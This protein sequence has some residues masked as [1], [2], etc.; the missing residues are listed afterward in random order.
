MASSAITIEDKGGNKLI[1]DKATVSG[2]TSG[3]LTR[4]EDA[5]D[6]YATVSYNSNGR[7]SSITTSDSRSID[8]SYNSSNLLSS[9][10]PSNGPVVYYT[11]SSNRLTTVTY[12]DSK[13]STYT[14]DGNKNLISARNHTGYKIVYT[15]ESTSNATHPHRVKTITEYAG[16][17]LGQSLTATYGWNTTLFTDHLGRKET[18]QFNNLG[19]LIAIRDTDGSAQYCAYMSEER[20]QSK[21]SSVSK[22]QKT[23]INLCSDSSFENDTAWLYTP[24]SECQISS[25]LAYMG[26]HCLKLTNH[27]AS[28]AQSVSQ[29]QS[30]IANEGQSVTLSAYFKGQSGAKLQLRDANHVVI[31]EKS[32]VCSD[33]WSR[34]SVA[35]TFDSDGYLGTMHLYIVLPA[36]Q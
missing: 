28:N 15:Y 31:A 8:L 2:V 11:Y 12:A 17:T 13:Q 20:M 22:V 33:E 5:N 6:N 21:L 19:Q 27:T 4:I 30:I 1:F 14:Y 7:I 29:A 23:T 24:T 3:K 35:H 25:E 32:V 16:S 36:G 34:E 26:M 10:P 18:Y 9:A